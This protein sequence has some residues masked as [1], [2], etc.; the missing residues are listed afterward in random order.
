MSS[1]TNV[2]Q[3]KRRPSAKDFGIA[4]QTGNLKEL[5]DLFQQRPNFWS[6]LIPAKAAKRDDLQLLKYLYEKAVSFQ[7]SMILEKSTF[8][9]AATVGNLEIL[10][11]LKDRGTPW[12]HRTLLNAIIAGKNIDWLLENGA[13]SNGRVYYEAKIRGLHDLAERLKDPTKPARYYSAYIR[14]R[15]RK[16]AKKRID[17]K[18]SNQ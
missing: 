17:S 7:V 9:S 4:A 16:L 13:P 2:I 14:T 12:D 6:V 15:R 8:A 3:S 10:K 1:T 18:A 11:W 5:E